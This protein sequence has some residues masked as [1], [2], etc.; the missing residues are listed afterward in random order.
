MDEYMN[1]QEQWEYVRNWLRQNGVWLVAGV[2]LAGIGLWGW[3]AWQ[4][5]VENMLMEANGQYQQVLAAF[6]KND[7][8]TAVKTADQLVATHP[9]TGYAEQAQLVVARMQVEN[10]QLPSALDR[11][12][13]V[14]ATTSDAQLSLVV[15]LRIARLQ[16][17]Q[18]RV[19]DA[20][21]TLSAVDPGALAGRFAEVRGDALLAKGDRT[22]ALKAYREAQSAQSSQVGAASA[23]DL[24]ALKI[25]ELT[26]S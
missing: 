12:Q 4:G 21:K 17:E 13:K 20:L 3:R 9:R 5:H 14:Q 6:A 24:L 18:N 2:A 1:E 19:D 10:N 8:P 11:L 16:I 23:G 15:R 26:R 7:L 25:N 22:G